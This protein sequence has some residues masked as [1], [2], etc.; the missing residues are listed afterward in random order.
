MPA[1]FSRAFPRQIGA[2]GASWAHSLARR[3][4]FLGLGVLSVLGTA[5]AVRAE[6][7]LLNPSALAA[8]GIDMQLFSMVTLSHD[9]S[10][11]IGIEKVKDLRMKQRGY[12]SQLRIFHWHGAQLARLDT[13]PLPTTAFEQLA[14][15]ADGSRAIA[16]G[17]GGSKFVVI[18]VASRKASILWTH[19]RGLP[20]FRSALVAWWR[21]GAFYLLG[22]L[23][24]GA[25]QVVF[26]GVVRL[27]LMRTGPDMFERALDIRPIMRQLRAISFAMYVDP[28][29]AFFGVMPRPGQVDIYLWQGATLRKI[30]QVVAL[31]GIASTRNRILYAARLAS[32]KR[33]VVLRDVS[34]KSMWHLGRGNLPFTYLFLSAD[35]KTVVITLMDF[36]GQTMSYFSAHEA[37]G[38]KQRPI[39]RLQDVRPGTLRLS[40]NGKVFAFYGPI[41]L[42]YGKVP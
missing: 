4:L 33:D 32:N 34:R 17:E 27:N 25:D 19:K 2:R 24:D 30:D 6:S 16:I 5:S 36:R 1:L 31:G 41:G 35:G 15:S 39:A 21:E 28:T 10:V 9:G 3:A 7:V 14:V 18:D 8:R 11:L 29:Q 26:D 42:L 13:I 37:D 22:Y 20:G 38:F 12:G 40:P 23:H